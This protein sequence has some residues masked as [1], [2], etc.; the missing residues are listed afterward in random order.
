[1]DNNFIWIII[2]ALLLSTI[3]SSINQ[4][5]N[6][7]KRTNEIL[8]RIAKQIGVPETSVDDEI[9]S[10]ILEGKKIKAIKVYRQSTRSGLKEAKE[11]I[12]LLCEKLKS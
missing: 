8:I 10:L 9:E 6:D 1:M 4:L 11:H 5:Q 7:V 2:G 12:D 3:L